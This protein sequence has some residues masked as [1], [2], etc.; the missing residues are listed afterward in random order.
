LKKALL[1]FLLSLWCSLVWGQQYG[2]KYQVY[3]KKASSAIEVDGVLDEQAWL[4]ADKA[5]DFHQNYPIDTIMALSASEVSFTYDQNN[6]YIGIV[7]YDPIPGD[8][9]VTSLRRD[10]IW[11]LNDNMSIYID[12]FDDLTN[13]FT[14]GITP[15]GIQ[16]E[17]LVT[18]G[19]RVSSNWDNKWYS[20]TKNHDDRWV[21]E[22]KIPFK[23]I[24]YNDQ[25][26]EWNIQMLRN[27]Q[28][29]NERSV[30]T[31]VP[32]QFRPSSFAFAGKLMWDEP[33]PPAGTNISLIPY[34]SGSVSQ[35]F[36]DNEDIAWE[37]DVGLDA[38]IALSSSLN[39]D[40]TVNPDFSQVEVDQQVTNL[41]RF[42]LFFPERRQFF[43]E[44]SDLF[45]N[46]G[47]PRSRV[48]FSRRVG[49]ANPILFG[50]RLSGKVD[51]NWR[52]GLLN[53]QTLKARIEDD[54]DIPTE[55]F[56]VATF[57]RQLFG[58]SNLAGVFLNKQAINFNEHQQEGYDF[59]DTEE[60]NRVFGLEYNL[61]TT[62][63]KWIGDTYY[64]RSMTPGVDSDNYAHGA[65]L[66]RNTRNLELT[67]S[68]ELIGDN[69]Q[70][71]AG[72]VPRTGFYRIGPSI[73][74]RF[75]PSS[76]VINRHGPELEFDLFTDTD[77]EITDHYL[78][79]AYKIQFLNTSGLFV[80]YENNFVKL[81]ED[82]DPT[83]SDDED[84]TI[85]PL[86]EGSEY[87]WQG[88]IL[89]YESD[90]RKSFSYALATSFGGFYNGE[91]FTLEGE[92]NFRI[93]PIF[94]LGMIYSFNTFSLPDPFPDDSFWLVGP[95][96][97]FTFTDKIFLTTF[98][99]YNEQD[100]NL[101]INTRFQWRFKPVSDL[102]I[103]YTDNYFPDGL[104]AKNRAL[105]IKL[106]YWLNI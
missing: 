90:R 58:R 35:D 36:E 26:Q 94:T 17:G 46:F 42:E 11:P 14:F 97:D 22:L 25:L 50:A 37:G 48:F 101:N 105:V 52:V 99:Q 9:V 56:T 55:N 15:L 91:I 72:F 104:Q 23:S 95:R 19:V 84:T 68:H 57:Q 66:R 20:A 67:W 79:V 32:Q 38:K 5:K 65:F 30:W 3:I 1:L 96:I 75:F 80:G 33:P 64:F 4:E 47:F 34:T 59:G 61:L 77:F 6:L 24:R 21:A 70:A 71:D 10:W 7:C 53:V 27:D 13:G 106:S 63:N 78:D 89:A 87:N 85:V 98:V 16:R 40:L 83:N 74:T 92:L 28:K 45:G 49:L 100:D 82:F 2:Y 88:A 8:Y 69:Y 44:N 31:P 29:Q 86:P 76:E 62:N 73:E 81:L 12:P 103:V 102:F 54:D 41:D 39:L 93:R 51:K 60:Y 43:L 18:F